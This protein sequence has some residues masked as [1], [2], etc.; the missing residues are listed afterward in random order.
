MVEFLILTFLIN[1]QFIHIVWKSTNVQPE[2]VTALLRHFPPMRKRS[3][4]LK[5]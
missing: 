2:V 3:S 4:S 5:L 1:V